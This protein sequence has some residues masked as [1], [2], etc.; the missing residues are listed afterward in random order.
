GGQIGVKMGPI[1]SE[2][3]TGNYP[4]RSIRAPSV[5]G[6]ASYLLSDWQPRTYPSSRVCN[7]ESA[8]AKQTRH[9]SPAAAFSPRNEN[10]RNPST[11][12]IIPI[13]GSTVHLRKP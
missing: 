4:P 2:L 8:N 3:L 1:L 11:S 12:L 5:A 10:W 7:R 13:T 9:H 6:R